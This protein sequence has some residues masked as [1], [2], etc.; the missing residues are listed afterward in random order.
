MACIRRMLRFT[1]REA[2]IVSLN[3]RRRHGALPN[4]TGSFQ[5]SDA[6]SPLDVRSAPIINGVAQLP[7]QFSGPGDHAF[8]AHYADPLAVTPFDG[9]ATLHLYTS[10]IHPQKST[11]QATEGLGALIRAAVTLP[12]GALPGSTDNYGPNFGPPAQAQRSR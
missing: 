4:I 6:Q 5:F 3:H 8:T 10:S 2:G 7:W 12:S 1:Q 11:Y 9:H